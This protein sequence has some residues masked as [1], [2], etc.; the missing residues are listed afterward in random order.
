MKLKG[1]ARQRWES[2]A[3]LAALAALFGGAALKNYDFGTIR[4]MGPGFFPVL[5]S[6]AMAI[7]AVLV[8]LTPDPTEDEPVSARALAAVLAGVAAF[9]GLV[10]TAGLFAAV[11]VSV[12]VCAIG[13][14][15]F[16]WGKIIL[17]GVAAA[18]FCS[19]LF[20]YALA[21]PIPLFRWPF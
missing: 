17:L 3:C 4:M 11:A 21:L 15:G 7:L 14:K 10:G 20:V 2:F 12:I 8:L 1:I 5:L 9:A 6:G 19:L 16:A 13:S 18:V